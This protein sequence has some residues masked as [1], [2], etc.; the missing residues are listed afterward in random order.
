MRNLVTIRIINQIK[1][2]ENADAIECLSV[3]G[4]TV[5]S[6]KGE[7]Q[8]GDYCVFYEIDSF[9]PADDVR[10]SFLLKGGTKKDPS[11]K[12]R[13]RLKTIKLR[14]QLS[15]GLALPLSLFPEYDVPNLSMTIGVDL[16]DNF[17]VI[18]YE[19]P[20]PKTANAAG[21]W[22]DCLIKT[23]EERIQNVYNLYN[24]FYKD[25]EYYATLKLDGSSCTVAFL[26]ED[27]KEYWKCSDEESDQQ[28]GI[29]VYDTDM[30]K[31][32]E[33]IVCSRN[34]Q[35]KYD[36]N[37][38]FWKAVED[39][40]LINDIQEIAIHY[41]S[42]LAIQGEVCGPG[43]Q[44][45]K[46]KFNNF[47]FFAFNILDIEKRVYIP[48]KDCLE[49]FEAHG[50]QNVPLITQNA[51]KPFTLFGTINSMI[52]YADGKSINAKYRE[53]IVFKSVNGELPSFKVISNKFL[54][55]GGDD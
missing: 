5:V 33:V 23:D 55:S 31:I 43:I 42:S 53:G 11:G 12:E 3:D 36:K 46:D 1:P 6:K 19:R 50:I 8:V 14:G 16:S 40:R 32:G 30:I 10:Y 34:L 27:K 20:E 29:V 9:L 24:E 2:I 28:A 37:S 17:N 39:S 38:H 13:I 22:P 47:E 48:Y 45:N 44:G 21:F 54:L 41:G 52:E 35:L 51:I 49:L 25:E 15:Q 26:G 7:F 4:W 18:K